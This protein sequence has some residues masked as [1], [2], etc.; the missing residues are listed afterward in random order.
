MYQSF[1]LYQHDRNFHSRDSKHEQETDKD[2][3]DTTSN[4][5]ATIKKLVTEKDGAVNPIK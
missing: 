5:Y 4:V 3:R 2:K 1:Q